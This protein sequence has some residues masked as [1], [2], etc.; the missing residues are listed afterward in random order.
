MRQ[1]HATVIQDG[2]IGTDYKPVRIP[3]ARRDTY[4]PHCATGEFE[5]QGVPT[6]R[7]LYRCT[8]YDC[9]RYW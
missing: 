4:C 1:D 6:N 7:Y 9:G 5:F 2:K 8:N 3:R